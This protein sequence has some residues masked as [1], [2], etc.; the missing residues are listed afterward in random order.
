M[1]YGEGNVYYLIRHNKLADVKVGRATAGLLKIINTLAP[2]AVFLL[3]A[4]QIPE[5]RG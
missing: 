5:H 2:R 4:A 1:K 3:N